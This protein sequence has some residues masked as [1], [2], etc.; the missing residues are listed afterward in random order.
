MSLKSVEELILQ[1][2]LSPHEQELDDS[3]QNDDNECP[4]CFNNYKSLNE[5]HCCKQLICTTCY[6]DVRN[7]TA[8]TAAAE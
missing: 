8:A 4:I 5:V 1:G 3:Y 6:V 7:T 2:K